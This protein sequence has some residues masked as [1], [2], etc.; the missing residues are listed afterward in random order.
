MSKFQ[1]TTLVSE[2][3]LVTARL[4]A[5]TGSSNNLGDKEVG[6]AVTLAGD[7]RY[8]L[9]SAGNAIEGVISA[10]AP[11]T[12]DGYT[13]GSVQTAN[14]LDVT[15]DGLEATPGVGVIAV[16]DYVVTGTVVAKGTALAA[17]L[18]VTQATDQTVAMNSPFAWRVVSLGSA[19]TGAVDTTGVIEKV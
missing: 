3:P 1:M 15:F 18:R 10:I 19:G 5:G 14:R 7:S 4:G 12:L 9:A 11:A 17:A 13:I 8:N 6:K 2:I 16:G